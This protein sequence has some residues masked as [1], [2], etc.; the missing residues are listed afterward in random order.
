M[1]FPMILV[2][3]LS[4][5]LAGCGSG[6]GDGDMQSSDHDVHPDGDLRPPSPELFGAWRNDLAS[7]DCRSSDD[8]NALPMED[9]DA[10]KGTLSSFNAFTITQMDDGVD[11]EVPAIGFLLQ[12]A[13]NDD[14]L[15][16]Y[17]FDLGALLPAPWTYSR[18]ATWTSRSSSNSPTRK[19]R[20]TRPCARTSRYRTMA[21]ARTRCGPG[22]DKP[23]QGGQRTWEG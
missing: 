5:V 21:A 11:I 15:L 18:T 10:M 4:L 7:F 14:G 3:A 19:V 23:D 12:G 22:R 20:S 2:L 8:N 17:E 16:I 9:L 6:G 13:I 1:A